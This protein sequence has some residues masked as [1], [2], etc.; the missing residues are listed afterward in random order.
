M[1]QDNSWKEAKGEP[2]RA[3]PGEA[4]ESGKLDSPQNLEA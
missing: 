4:W 2:I 3:T 1:V